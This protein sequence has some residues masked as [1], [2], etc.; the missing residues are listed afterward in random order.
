M[1]SKRLRK[2]QIHEIWDKKN[3]E[4]FPL[5]YHW[6]LYNLIKANP[7]ITV[8]E[9]CEAMPE[10]YSYKESEHNFTNCPAIYEDIDYLMSSAR[11]EKIIIKDNGTFRLGTEEECIEYANKIFLKAKKLMAKYGVIAR[12]I[13][14]DKQGKLFGTNLQPIDENSQARPFVETFI[15]KE[16]DYGELQKQ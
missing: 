15:D 12:R 14:K 10:Y 11:I 16:S 3:E 8:K 6:K 2:K 7:G 4:F 13:P 9:I 1:K 5:G